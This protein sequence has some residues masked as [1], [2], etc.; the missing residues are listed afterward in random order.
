MRTKTFHSISYWGISNSAV[1]TV[2]FISSKTIPP[3]AIVMNT[4]SGWDPLIL[5]NFL[6]LQLLT[7][8]DTITILCNMLL[9][10]PQFVQETP[11]YS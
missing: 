10:T 4:D 9:M 11:L 5:V 7:A 2:S 1:W 8:T 6:P 3:K